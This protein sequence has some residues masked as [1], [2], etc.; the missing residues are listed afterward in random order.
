M[1]FSKIK[2]GLTKKL[3]YTKTYKIYIIN[4]KLKNYIK[5]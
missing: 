1:K 4:N 3:R 5:N 2:Y